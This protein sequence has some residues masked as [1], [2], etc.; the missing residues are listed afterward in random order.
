MVRSI[1]SILLAAAVAV[2]FMSSAAQADQIIQLRSGNG[3]LNGVDS[4]ITMLVG[5]ADTFFPNTFTPADFAAARNGAQARIV[6]RNSSWID[7][8]TFSDPA[9]QWITDIPQFVQGGQPAGGGATLGSSVLFA[10]DFTITDAFI[11][12][13]EIDFDFSVDNGLGA[14]F[15][16][17][18]EGLF[19]NGTALSGSTSGGHFTFE[20]NIFRND[21]APLLTT[22]TN[23]LY[24]NMTDVGTPSGLLFSA[25]ITTQGSETAAISEPGIVATFGLG[26][27]GLGLARRKRPA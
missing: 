13:A 1:K 18:N 19:I 5:P 9:A 25:T 27:I 6:P 17:P 10:I 2:A 8:A 21:I 22:G 14:A 26:L 15:G 3:P 23:T 20:D 4:A 16:G 12:A 24:I 7:P 11:T